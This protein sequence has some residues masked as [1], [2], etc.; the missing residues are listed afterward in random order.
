MKLFAIGDLHLPG[1]DEKPMNVFGDHW[2]HHFAR[3]CEDWQARVAADDVVLIPGDITWAMHMDK[4]TVDLQAIGSLPG[5]KIMIRGNH[6][7]WWSSINRVRLACPEGLYALQND[8]MDLGS[9]IVCGSRG[10]SIPT[11]D[12]PLGPEDVKILNRELIRMELSLQAAKKLQQKNNA[13]LVVMMHFPPLYDQERQTAF[14]ALMEQYG[15]AHVIYGHLH[16]IGI[17]VGYTGEWQGTNYHLT[18]C[19]ALDFKLKEIAL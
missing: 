9:M 16:G 18:S 8:A 13:P 14:T 11:K 1:G 10:W 2:D 3:I 6:D 4:A 12:T 7:Y 17:K 15:A 5:K 19:D